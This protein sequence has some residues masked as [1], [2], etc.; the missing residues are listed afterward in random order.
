MLKS[1]TGTRIKELREARGLTQFELSE[2]SG[3]HRVTIARYE[4]GDIGI[5]L[6]NAARIAD[7]L[8]CT[9]ND[10]IGAEDA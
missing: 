10:L 5:S 3:I 8:G 2:R 4:I 6:E 9:V 1:N 7:A